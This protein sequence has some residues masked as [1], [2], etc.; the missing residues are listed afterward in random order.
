[1]ESTC[2]VMRRG[3]CN[4][5]HYTNDADQPVAKHEEHAHETEHE[6]GQDGI[7]DKD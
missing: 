4:R 6:L 3:C 2:Q 7:S 1:M 5:E